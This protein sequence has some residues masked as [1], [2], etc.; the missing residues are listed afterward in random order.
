MTPF[1]RYDEWLQPPEPADDTEPEDEDERDDLRTGL[2]QL[3]ENER[4]ESSEREGKIGQPQSCSR[5]V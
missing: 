5:D 1:G 2:R 4:D 3:E